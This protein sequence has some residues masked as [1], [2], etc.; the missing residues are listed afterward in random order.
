L[1]E[2]ATSCI[3]AVAL[4]LVGVTSGSRATDTEERKSTV[5]PSRS[6]SR[7]GPDEAACPVLATFVLFGEADGYGFP[8]DVDDEVDGNCTPSGKDGREDEPEHRPV[9]KLTVG[10]FDRVERPHRVPTLRAPCP[11]LPHK[12]SGVEPHDIPFTS[13]WSADQ[14]LAARIRTTPLLL[15]R[16]A[17][18]P[19]APPR[20]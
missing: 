12:L 16:G 20:C 19:H 7:Q 15:L 3:A 13:C 10:S 4:A 11:R 18:E 9:S 2:R 17:M 5:A 6:A 8:A 14:R 1:W